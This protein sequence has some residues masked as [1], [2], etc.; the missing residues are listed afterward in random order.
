[1]RDAQ[2]GTVS[3]FSSTFLTSPINCLMKFPIKLIDVVKC[4]E[5]QELSHFDK[6][7]ASLKMFSYGLNQDHCDPV[8][9]TETMCNEVY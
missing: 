7:N 8:L 1:M 6:T 4:D 9:V 3:Y 5:Q 2:V